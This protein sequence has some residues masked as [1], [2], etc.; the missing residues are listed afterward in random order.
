MIWRAVFKEGGRYAFSSVSRSKAYE[1][2]HKKHAQAGTFTKDE[3]KK[4]WAADFLQPTFMLAFLAERE[5]FEPSI[6][7]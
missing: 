7:V 6:Q 2:M 3:D 5:G 1:G 4:R